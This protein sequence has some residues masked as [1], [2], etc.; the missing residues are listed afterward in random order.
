MISW[1]EIK[2]ADVIQ[3]NINAGG[4]FIGRDKYDIQVNIGKDREHISLRNTID[5]FENSDNNNTILKRKLTDGELNDFFI[6]KAI[7]KKIK[8]LALILQIKKIDSGKG[9]LNDMYENLITL[10][11]T[12][13]LGKLENGDLLKDA[14]KFAL[15]EDLQKLKSDFEKQIPIDEAFF[16]GLLYVA[17]SNCAIK[18]RVE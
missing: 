7:E 13:Y 3:K 8:T 16:E 4:D 10:F 15:Y 1:E 12:K 17:T 9:Y 18:W 14:D 6:S 5:L 2:L 11:D